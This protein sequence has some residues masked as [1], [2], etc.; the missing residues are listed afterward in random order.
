MKKLQRYDLVRCYYFSE[1]N[2]TV[3]YG[4]KNNHLNG[5]ST[6]I[7]KLNVE[8]EHYIHSVE[9]IVNPERQIEQKKYVTWEKCVKAI[10]ISF[11]ST[12]VIFILEFIISKYSHS[13]VAT[14]FFIFFLLL[15][16]I[17]L[18]CFLG[19]LL[20][21]WIVSKLYY[22]YVSKI[23]AK[24]LMQKQIFEEIARLS[25]QSIDDL[26]LN[27]LEPMYRETVIMR[28]EQNEHNK[29][30]E[31]IAEQKYRLE[32][33]Q[34]VENRKIRQAQENLLEIE[35]ERERRYNR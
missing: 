28:R 31:R 21:E 29:K 8:K 2:N 24:L 17:S 20:V 7:D 27:S 10:K 14:L 26:Y 16:F 35:Q 32:L 23:N 11:C 13:L 22:N 15:F 30:M 1:Y 33:E 19:A 9:N 5:V 25:Y 12:I 4:Q 34:L 3:E 18:V 6:C